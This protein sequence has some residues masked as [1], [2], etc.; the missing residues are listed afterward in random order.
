MRAFRHWIPVI[1]ICSLLPLAAEPTG[2]SA[3]AEQLWQL[4]QDAMLVEQPDRA[5]TFYTAS[6]RADPTLAR[7]FLSLAA[8]HLQKGEEDSAASWLARYVAVQPDHVVV[9]SHYAE[10]LG[11]LGKYDSAEVQWHRYVA[12]VQKSVK[13]PVAQLLQAHTRL[14]EIAARRKDTHGEQLHRG[15]G[16]YWLAWLKAER[17][18]EEEGSPESLLCQATVHLM[19]ARRARPES[20]RTCWYLQRVWEKLGQQATARKWLH[21]ASQAAAMPGHDLT[22]G[23]LHDLELARARD[24][25]RSRP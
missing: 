15:I 7:N 14:M 11:K 21:E 8:A 9:R 17:G 1:V 24:G 19:Q 5:I 22:A 3:S 23:E 13:Q 6:L 20:A 10:L 2:E 12:D 25:E 16:L 4:G 18:T